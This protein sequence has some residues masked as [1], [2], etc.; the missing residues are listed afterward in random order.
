M[1]INLLAVSFTF[2]SP[3]PTDLPGSSALTQVTNGL[4]G[5]ALILALVGLLIG[6]VTW[7]LSSHSQNYQHAVTGRRAVLLSGLA[8][9]LIG[10]GPSIVQF[11]YDL[12]NKAH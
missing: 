7:A 10:A 6:A 8:A 2:F 11:F 4:G 12:G 9:L 1:M 5:W 3:Q